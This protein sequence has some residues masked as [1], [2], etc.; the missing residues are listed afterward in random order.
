MVRFRSL[1]LILA[2]LILGN[3]SQIKSQEVVEFQTVAPQ[4]GDISELRISTNILPWIA[5]IP[6]IGV[7]YVINNKWSML[8]DVWFCPWKLSDK[9]SVKTVAI[10]PEGR[11]W[12]KTSGKGSFFN[13]HLNLAWFN[14]RA[15]AY[16]YQDSSRPLL[17]AG[18]GY[19]YR[20]PLNDK[21]G[22]EF[23]IGAGVANAKYDRFYNVKNGA[24]KD[25]RVS[26]YWGIDRASVSI[27]Y[28]LCDL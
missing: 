21:W 15:N 1:L 2:F 4:T 16:R 24:L 5:T 11:W 3:T 20:L 13:V 9:F 27:T 23:E 8:L 17:G 18:I 19:G 25:T 22:F 28:N 7:E 10:L 14:V 6:N 12:L 26:T